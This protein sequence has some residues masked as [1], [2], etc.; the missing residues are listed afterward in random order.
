LLVLAFNNHPHIIVSRNAKNT[1][2]VKDA[3]S[4]KVSVRKVLTQVGLGTIFSDIARDNPTIK[5]KVSKQALRYIVTSLGCGCAA[6]P[7]V[8][9]CTHSIVC[10]RQNAVSCTDSLQSMRSIAHRRCRPRGR[11][12]DRAMSLQNQWRPA[13]SRQAHARNGV[14]MMCRTGSARPSSALTA[15]ITLI[16]R[17][18]H[19]RTL[20]R[21]RYRSTYTSTRCPCA[22]TARS[23]GVSSLF[24]S[25]PRSASSI[26][27]T[28][29]PPSAAGATIP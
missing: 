3:D 15:R 22:R 7:S 25:A 1:L 13:P 5:G 14:L 8:L 26:A 24:S 21:R 2:Q 19:G 20:L 17:R 10:C 9:A 27:C 18:R 16:R 23:G 11:Q 29:G 6:A 28:M 12:G 4:E